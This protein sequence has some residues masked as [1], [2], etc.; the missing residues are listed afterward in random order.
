LGRGKNDGNFICRSLARHQPLLKWRRGNHSAKQNTNMKNKIIISGMLAAALIA[1]GVTGCETEKQEQAKLQAQAKISREQAQQT[2]LAKVPGS[3]VKEG[4]L[5]KE[6]GRLIWSFDL[7]T[8]DSKDITEVNV[9]AIT[10]GV[11][12]MGKEKD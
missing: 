11:V 1:L 5:E 7:A 2:A 9:D 4:E 3:T 12:S 10:G 6:K 8:P